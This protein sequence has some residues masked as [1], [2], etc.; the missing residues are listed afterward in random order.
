MDAK[1]PL[2]IVGG[3]SVGASSELVAVAERLG[4]AV[5]PTIAGKGVIPDSHPL[6]LEATLD[7][8]ATQAMIAEADVVL[9]VGTELAEPDIWLDGPLPIGGKM[10]RIDIDP[11]TLVRDY[12]RLLSRR[13]QLWRLPIFLPRCP[14]ACLVG[15]VTIRWRACARRKEK[16]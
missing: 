11:E 1:R 12:P 6:A 14:G 4:A 13:T 7:R 15:K 10:I 5:V 9:C 2:I 8:Q 3:G 16:R